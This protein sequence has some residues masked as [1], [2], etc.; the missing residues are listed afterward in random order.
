MPGPA[1]VFVWPGMRMRSVRWEQRATADPKLTRQ[2]TRS[3]KNKFFADQ[4]LSAFF[5]P[6]RGVRI[7]VNRWP[8]TCE[9]RSSWGLYALIAR[10]F[11]PGRFEGDLLL[12]IA[13]GE[14]AEISSHEAWAARATGRIE[15]HGI[16]CQHL[17]DDPTPPNYGN[18]T[19]AGTIL[20]N[21]RG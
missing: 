18:R 1:A 17:R 21:H 15:A 9:L 2:Y 8:S 16:D 6:P 13:T 14:Q 11:R 10:N 5:D 3:F 12:F 7:R 19:P 20:K 4:A